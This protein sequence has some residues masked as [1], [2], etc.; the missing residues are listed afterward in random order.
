MAARRTK[1]QL[2]ALAAEAAADAGTAPQ[3][4]PRQTP[5]APTAAAAA[6]AAGAAAYRLAEFALTDNDGVCSWTAKL[7]LGT[8]PAASVSF[9]GAKKV[10]TVTPLA[11]TTGAAGEVAK[12][13]AAATRLLGRRNATQDLI[14]VLNITAEAGIS[15]HN[16][17][18]L[19]RDIA[20]SHD[21]AMRP[22][23]IVA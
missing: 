15:A 18:A 17:V 5:P 3:G 22:E 1:A 4:R 11:K 13:E 9:N 7:L 8:E 2:E 20:G 16:R 19:L 12:F 14:L 23:L 21:L 10:A 6:T